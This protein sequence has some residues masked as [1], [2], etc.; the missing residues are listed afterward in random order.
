MIDVIECFEL[1]EAK[2]EISQLQI[3]LSESEKLNRQRNTLL[4]DIVGNIRIN[5]N[6]IIGKAVIA[7]TRPETVSENADSIIESA[8]AVIELANNVLDITMTDEQKLF[9]NESQFEIGEFFE[10]IKS[11]VMSSVRSK[12]Q[13]LTVSYKDIKHSAVIGDSARLQTIFTNLISNAVKYTLTGGVIKVTVTETEYKKGICCFLVQISDNGVGMTKEKLKNILSPH[14]SFYGIPLASELIKL[15]GGNIRIDSN[16]G[17]GTNVYVSFTLKSLISEEYIESK[18]EYSFAGKRIL[19]V[20]DNEI[21]R[22]MFTEMLES[23]GAVVKESNDGETAVKTFENSPVNHFDMIFMDI[24]MPGMDGIEATKYI[25]S[26]YRP[27]AKTIP[28]IALTAKT[29]GE[30]VARGLNVGMDAYEQK[31]F[32]LN[33]IRRLLTELNV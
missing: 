20:E 15:F 4:E 7:K 24:A 25:R 8:R 33:R 5:L 3:R 23:E 22:E 16:P 6:N 19:L 30:E 28:I 32:D 1:E 29:P 27:D 14:S 10:N 31:P 2:R 21:S 26:M 17:I 13:R 11:A 12:S 18:P 9:L